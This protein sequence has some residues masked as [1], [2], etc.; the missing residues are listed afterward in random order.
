M[1][2][3]CI[4]GEQR[5]NCLIL[6]EIDGALNGSEGRS[7][8]SVILDLINTPLK[9]S[10]KS[11]RNSHPLVRPLICI[12]NDQFAPVLRPLRK[13][14]IVYSM[15]APDQSRIMHRLKVRL[16]FGQKLHMLIC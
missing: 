4:W 3:G 16:V 6:D 8:V 12:C 2:M 14:A 9:D 11:G 13:V 5:P 15:N 7:A 1:E 10:K